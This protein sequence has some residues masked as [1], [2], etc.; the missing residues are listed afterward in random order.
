MAKQRSNWL[1]SALVFLMAT[2]FSAPGQET[3][4]W[5]GLRQQLFGERSIA[6]GQ[7]VSLEAPERA[8]NPAVV[9][10]AI[11]AELPPG[12]NDRV[13]TLYLIIDKN[14]GPLAA[15]FHLG[16]QGGSTFLSTRVRVNEY[17]HIRAIA[18]TQQGRL[19]MA[20]R[21]VKASGGCAAPATTD[22]KAAKAMLG[23]IRVFPVGNPRSL[24][25]PWRMQI[26]IHHPN[27]SGLQT[28]QL[29]H[30]VIPA[31]FVKRISV[32]YEGQPVLQA[33][34]NISLSEN[35]SLRFS[36]VPGVPGTLK[37]EVTDTQDKHFEGSMQIAPSS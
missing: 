8:E 12:D 22:P 1:L 26:M 7:V 17:T 2:P 9:P 21:F 3:D 23:R 28:D 11:R 36:F 27:D 33:E 31:Y 4:I 32:S 5:P 6:E 30:L 15:V 13:K 20:K 10:I 19:Y 25:D 18:E 16:A 35:P 24:T 29:T 37:V 14:P 34:T